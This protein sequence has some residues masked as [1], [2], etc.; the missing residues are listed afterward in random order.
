M[1]LAVAVKETLTTWKFAKGWHIA[2]EEFERSG[3][4]W[5]TDYNSSSQQLSA[6]SD[7]VGMAGIGGSGKYAYTRREI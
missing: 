7:R 5:T 4:T 6:A 3:F 2:C 1:F